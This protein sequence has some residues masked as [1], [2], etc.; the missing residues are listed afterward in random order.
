MLE[1]HN[2]IVYNSVT[3]IYPAFYF[4]NI[5]KKTAIVKIKK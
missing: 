5:N 3:E 1:M 4:V 2:K